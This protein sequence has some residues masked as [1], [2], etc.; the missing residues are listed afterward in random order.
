LKKLSENQNK[1]SL[2]KC[3]EK[4]GEKEGLNRFEERQVKWQNT[5]KH[6][7][8][9]KGYWYDW[10][11]DDTKLFTDFEL[12]SKMVRRF[13]EQND[14]TILKDFEKRSKDFHVDHRFS[15]LEGFKNNIPPYIIGSLDN[16]EILS[17]ENNS[18][19]WVKCSV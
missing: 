1:F 4:Y 12:Y 3:I 10:E 7:M 13:T 17:R 9:S 16:L 19:K 15:I 5:M 8:I 2:E 6:V 11:G 18:R 14:L